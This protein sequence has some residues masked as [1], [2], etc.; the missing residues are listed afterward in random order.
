MSAC[1]HKVMSGG[2]EDAGRRNALDD[3]IIFGKRCYKAMNAAWLYYHEACLTPVAPTASKG[4]APSPRCIAIHPGDKTA[5]AHHAPNGRGTEVIW[6]LECMLQP[7][8]TTTPRHNQ[9][10]SAAY[11]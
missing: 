8:C 6:I 10:L 1:Q 5:A 9:H 4:V 7:T 2:C 3:C 11:S